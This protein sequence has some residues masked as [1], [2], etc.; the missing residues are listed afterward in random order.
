MTVGEA[1]STTNATRALNPSAGTV[2]TSYAG[3]GPLSASSYRSTSIQADRA[4][5]QLALAYAKHSS[6]K[7]SLKS[8]KSVQIHRYAWLV[9]QQPADFAA[10]ANLSAAGTSPSHW[11]VERYVEESRLGDLI[12]ASFFT[13][14]ADVS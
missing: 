12:A 5:P 14:A 3:P 8:D 2:I 6:H 1:A 11:S 7:S 13:V 4:L 9:F 10:P